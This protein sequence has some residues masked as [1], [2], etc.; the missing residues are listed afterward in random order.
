MNYLGFSIG[1]YNLYLPFALAYILVWLAVRLAIRGQKPKA[2]G[3]YAQEYGSKRL[4]YVLG[5]L[6]HR[7][8][9][10]A[11]IFVPIDAHLVGW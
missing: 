7:A 2:V 9:M 11:S 10:L 3:D 5:Y 6:P 4:V 1:L 8:L